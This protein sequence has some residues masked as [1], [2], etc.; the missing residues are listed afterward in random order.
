[1]TSL[2]RSFSFAENEDNW[3]RM[4]WHCAAE[5]NSMME[6]PTSQIQTHEELTDHFAY[7]VG[8]RTA[9]MYAAQFSGYPLIKY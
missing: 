7:T 8:N 9:L 5:I 1:M 6:P 3:H 4:R 2:W